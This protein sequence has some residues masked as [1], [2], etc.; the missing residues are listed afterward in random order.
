MTEPAAQATTSADDLAR[1][2]MGFRPRLLGIAYR[3]LGSAWDAEDVVAEAMVRWLHVDRPQVREPLAFLTTVVTRLALDQ[4]RSARAQRESYVGPWLPEPMATEPSPLGPL[5]TVERRETVSLATLRMMEALTPAERAVLVLHEAFDLPHAEIAEILD[6]TVEG[7]RQHLRRARARVSGTGKRFRPTAEAHDVLLGRFMAALEHGDLDA[8][9]D[10]LAA[11]VV[12]YSDGGGKVRRAPPDRGPGPRGPLLPG[13][14][15]PARGDRRAAHRGERPARGV[16]PLRPA[17]GGARPGRPRRQDP[18]ADERAQ[19]RQ[20]AL[21]AR[22]ARRP[23]LSGT[24]TGLV[25]RPGRCTPRTT[26]RGTMQRVPASDRE[27]TDGWRAEV[28]DH[29]LRRRL[30]RA[31]LRRR[32]LAPGARARPLALVVRVRHERRPAAAPLPVRGQRRRPGR[33]VRG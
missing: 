21:P 14:A 6:I 17:G 2:F 4:L 22:P 3:M 18:R 5:D 33:G 16:V 26:L 9:E 25:R 28:A 24:A 27:L 10:V 1:E 8:L 23:A 13:P 12:H 11:D 29:H 31:R 20:A 15:P 7:S 19:P 30:R 32:C